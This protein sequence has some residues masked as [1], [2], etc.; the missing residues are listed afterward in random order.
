[1]PP[2]PAGRTRCPWG[3]H[4][5]FQEPDGTITTARRRG[6]PSTRVCIR[7]DDLDLPPSH[8]RPRR[9]VAVVTA[10]NPTSVNRLF[11]DV[12]RQLTAT[13]KRNVSQVLCA[14]N[15]ST[16][17][18]TTQRRRAI[19]NAVRLTNGYVT[20]LAL[21]LFMAT[22]EREERERAQSDLSYL[23]NRWGNRAQWRKS[24]SLRPLELRDRCKEMDDDAAWGSTFTELQ[25][26]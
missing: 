26:L 9:N 17:S 3:T 8:A 23:T 22:S 21:T 5:R 20:A 2:L 13:E 1:M 19:E 14:A 4:R 7:L 25:G 18:R 15:Y 12:T 24:P 6:I 10:Q 11:R 16:N